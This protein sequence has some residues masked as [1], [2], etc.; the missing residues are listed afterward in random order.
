M[1]VTKK[2]LTELVEAHYKLM[3]PVRLEEEKTEFQSEEA[4]NESRDYQVSVMKEDMAQLMAKTKEC[5]SKIA[6]GKRIISVIKKSGVEN[7]GFGKT[8]KYQWNEEPVQ[9]LAKLVREAKTLRIDLRNALERSYSKEKAKFEVQLALR[10]RRIE[11]FPARRTYEERCALYDNER[12]LVS[13]A[14]EI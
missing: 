9:A 14:L 12:A 1:V 7:T 13:A 5:K 4:W 3:Y 2:E 8:M 11:G 6:R 10:N